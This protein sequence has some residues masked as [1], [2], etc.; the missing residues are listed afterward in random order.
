MLDFSFSEEQELFRTN[1]RRFCR[2]SVV[3]RLDEIERIR[4]IPDDLIKA[5]ADMGLIAMSISE[6]YGGTG[7]DA[8]TAGIAAEELAFADTSCAIPAFFLIQNAWA[9]LLDK[10]GTEELKRE[11]LPRVKSGESF[12]GVATTEPDIGS[13]LASMKTRIAKD[14]NSYVV[15][16][17]K[18]YI[19]GVREA[20]RYGGG[21]VTLAKMAPEQGTRGMSLF[22]LPI[23]GTPGIK[24]TYL[25]ELGREGISWGGFFIDEVHIPKHYLIGEENRGFYIVHEGYEFARG[26]IALVCVGAALKS[27]ENAM[28]Y[29]KQREAFGRAI[30]RYEGLQFALAEDYARIEAARLL[31]YKALWLYDREQKGEK[32]SRFEVSKAVAIAKMLAPIWAF[33]AINDAMQWQGAFGYSRE[34]QEQRALRGVRSFTLAEGST[35]VMKLIVAR[36]LLGKEYL[37]YR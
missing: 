35:E 32:I 4:G 21:Y 26:M 24:V 5:M 10:Y 12:L 16:G 13:D 11:V 17:E 3:P 6:K 19:S 31:A 25:E 22:Y 9:Y 33:D 23:K 29:M 34:C 14:G 15:S 30:A 7:L 36:E 27:L 20:E 8:V 1:L 2:Q 28:N 18:N 37:A